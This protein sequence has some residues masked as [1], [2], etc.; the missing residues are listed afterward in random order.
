MK[1]LLTKINE[2]PEWEV[3]VAIKPRFDS[4]GEV[5]NQVKL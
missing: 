3:D 2:S 1:L 5:L 4:T